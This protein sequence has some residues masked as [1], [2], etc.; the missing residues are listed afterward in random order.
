[1]SC[2]TT[3]CLLDTS[4]QVV[5]FRM[6]QSVM[7]VVEGGMDMFDGINNYLFLSLFY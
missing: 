1:M 2:S 6:E 5:R 7:Q 3:M 4:W